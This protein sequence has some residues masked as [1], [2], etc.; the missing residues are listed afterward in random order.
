LAHDALRGAP[1]TID[2]TPM[3]LRSLSVGVRST[4]DAAHVRSLASLSARR[5]RLACFRAK[6]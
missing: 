2:P 5:T 1:R 6:S 4:P 3:S